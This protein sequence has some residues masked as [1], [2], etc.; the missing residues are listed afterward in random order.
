LTKAFN[1]DSPLF[2]DAFEVIFC[3]IVVGIAIVCQPHII[4]KSLLLKK[5]S[6]V[7]RYLIAGVTAEILFFS[8]VIAGIFARIS[9]P[10]LMV[11]EEKIGVDGVIPAYVVKT[12]TSVTGII[13]I[14]GLI[15]A[16]I[17]TLEGLIQTL[18]TTI[19]SDLLHP[20][21]DHLGKSD[22]FDKW[23]ININRIVIFFLATLAFITSFRQLV[24]P[25]LSVGIFAQNGVYAFFSAAFIPVLMGSF[26]K[27]TPYYIPFTSSVIALITHFGVYYGR[28][29]PYMQEEVRNPAVAATIAI[30]SATIVGFTMLG[31]NKLSKVNR[32][33]QRVSNDEI[34]HVA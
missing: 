10:D 15:S 8:V 27:N 2:R 17:S 23:Q 29:T 26:L 31:I 18:S 11:N 3:Q 9:F 32:T 7:N 4:T 24:A 28:L 19:T 30:L 13:V 25:D 22:A 20:L 5:D 6:D 33:G 21:F 1:S 16:G 12:F 14:L 34:R